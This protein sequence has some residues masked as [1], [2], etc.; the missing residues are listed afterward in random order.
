[1]SVSNSW[2]MA[3]YRKGRDHSQPKV[4]FD[5]S[6]SLGWHS[7]FSNPP[8]P[9]NIKNPEW[10]SIF[11]GVFCVLLFYLFIYLFFFGR[12]GGEAIENLDLCC[13]FLTW[14]KSCKRTYSAWV[15]SWLREFSCHPLM[16]FWQHILRC[17]ARWENCGILVSL[18][19]AVHIEGCSE[20]WWLSSC[21]SALAAQAK[22]P[23]FDSWQLLAFSLLPKILFI[24]TWS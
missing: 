6:M 11:G 20:A 15:V 16:E 22:C 17:A 4:C 8:P 18:T 14:G 23:G 21:R 13:F 1:M 7:Q 10:G 3:Y 12:G 19:H 24:Q 9:K 2:L 5:E